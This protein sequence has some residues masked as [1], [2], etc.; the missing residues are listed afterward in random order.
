MPPGPYRAITC[1][2][3]ELTLDHIHTFVTTRGQGGPSRMSDQPNSGATSETI[4]KSIGWCEGCHIRV[5]LDAQ[6]PA[7][8]CLCVDA[9]PVSKTNLPPYGV[10][11]D[12]PDRAGHNPATE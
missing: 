11:Q 8:Y 12:R 10:H 9:A 7:R 6:R 3:R 1:R 4:N 2:E 5:R